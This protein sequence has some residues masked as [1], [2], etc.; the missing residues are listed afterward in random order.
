MAAA[1]RTA[2]DT[3]RLLRELAPQVLGA[4]V[5]RYGA[6]DAAEDAV[7]EALLAAAL[8]WP[9][10]GI[11][12]NPRAW[13]ITVASRR[14]ADRLR[15]ESARRR[16]ESAALTPAALVVPAP[17][18]EPPVDADDTLK[19]LFLCCHP[20]LSPPSQVALTLRAVGGLT[21]AQIA[22]AFLVPEATMAQRISRAKH[23]IRAA[24]ARF[25]MPP[26]DER[27]D[28]L[29]AVMHVLYLTFN[30]GYTATSGSDLH[31]PAL[32]D[33]AIRLCRSLHGLL[34]DDREISGLLALM[35]LTDAR[36]PARTLP[37][38]ALVPLADQDRSRWDVESIREGVALI[39]NALSHGSMGPYQLQAAIAAVHDEAARPEDTDWPQILALYELLEVVSPNPMV[40]L[41]HAVALAMVH[42]PADALELL[43][44]LDADERMS[45]QHRLEAVRAHLLE[46]V[47]DRPAALSSYRIAARLTSSLPERRYLEARA[48]TLNSAAVSGQSKRSTTAVDR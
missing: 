37:D 45:K 38:G 48:A 19:L 43:A 29:R 32:T 13:L 4:L 28:R 26:A 20:A 33:E 22:R 7:Q 31:R 21:T 14:H 47:G 44:A 42:G 5:R 40:T 24:G 46:M 1:E 23:A 18:D 30:E 39:S 15:A 3:E 2:A 9:D 35:L 12:E 8:Q 16:R 36:R 11:P 34:P 27:P 25:S 41:N 17:G 6:F 10:R